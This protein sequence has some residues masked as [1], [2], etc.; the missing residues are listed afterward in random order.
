MKIILIFIIL[1]L[2]IIIEGLVI[3]MLSKKVFGQTGYIKELENTIKAQSK[4]YGAFNEIDKQEQNDKNSINYGSMDNR[5]SS[6][7]SILQNNKRS[8]N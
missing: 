5:L 7:V 4:V 8:R 6:A 2:F 3:F 1:G